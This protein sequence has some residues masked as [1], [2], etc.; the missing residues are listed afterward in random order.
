VDSP[1]RDRITE[2]LRHVRGDRIL[3]IGCSSHIVA[4][5]SQ[6]WL[7]GRLAERF[8]Q[9]VGVD[10]HTDNMRRMQ[11]LGYRRLIVGEAER[12]PLEGRFD[13]IV[14]GE[15]IEHLSNPGAFFAGARA[16]LSAEGRI[17]VTTPYPFS[18]LNMLYAFV[19]FPRTCQNPE[20]ACWF[21]PRTMTELARRAD[22]RVVVWEL[23]EDYDP[24]DPSPRYR[25]FVHAMRGL[26]WLF[27]R[28]LR[29]NAMLFMLADA[30]E[31]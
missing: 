5:G 26:R 8:P 14:A 10:I 12:L 29:C 28:R 20:H 6:R 16:L 21:C 17:I 7:H 19:K 11:Q 24:D 27:P 1:S 2:I 3:D 13:T 15:V 23:V 9:V 18:L 30:H 22:L 25:W 4:A 31:G